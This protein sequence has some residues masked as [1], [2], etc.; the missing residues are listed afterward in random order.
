MRSDR[1]VFRKFITQRLRNRNKRTVQ[2]FPE[3]GGKRIQQ[4][5]RPLLPAPRGGSRAVEFAL[6][7]DLIG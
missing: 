4:L 1:K 7:A 3:T 2:H 6:P 5:S